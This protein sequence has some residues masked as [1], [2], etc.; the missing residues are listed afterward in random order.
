MSLEDSQ[1]PPQSKRSG[2]QL[3]DLRIRIL[4]KGGPS[5]GKMKNKTVVKVLCCYLAT[6]LFVL[7][8]AEKVYAGFSPSEVLGLSP[9]ERAVDLGKVR[10]ALETKVVQERL[11]QLGFG[12]DE[13]QSR[14]DQLS[15]QQ[16]HKVAL[17]IDELK[18][19]GDG[20]GVVIA[21]LLIA[22]LVLLVVYLVPHR[23]R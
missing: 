5:M 20:G 16:L 9:V 15:D 8:V 11:S 6:A 14:L 19:G 10:A 3:E 22:I 13:I 2:L 1:T 12:R 18:V 23:R 7:G 21:V 17:K 4:I